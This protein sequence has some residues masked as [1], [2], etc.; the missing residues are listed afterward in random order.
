MITFKR[1]TF[2]KAK[3]LTIEPKQ[4]NNDWFMVACKPLHD[5]RNMYFS[6]PLL[7]NKKSNERLLFNG[8]DVVV[9]NT[10][11]KASSKIVIISI[12]YINVKSR[13]VT[14]TSI[15]YY[16]SHG[17]QQYDMA[18]DVRISEH[19]EVAFGDPLWL[20]SLK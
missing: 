5:T 4:I 12:K 8:F 1:N 13:K 11:T 20:K 6:R 10:L 3:D 9:M 7:Q 2:E 14:K 18:S 16:G 19:L 17:E 15:R